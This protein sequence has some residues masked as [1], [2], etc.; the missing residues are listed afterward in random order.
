MNR[1]YGRSLLQEI[2]AQ[3]RNGEGGSIKT[4]LKREGARFTSGALTFNMTKI[5][6]VLSRISE[7]N[8]IRKINDVKD[9]KKF[10]ICNRMFLRVNI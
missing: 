3:V 2:A 10:F 7:E 9:T 5:K 4:F 6:K 1:I 8:N